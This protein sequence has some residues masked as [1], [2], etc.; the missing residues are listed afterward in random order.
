[1]ANRGKLVWRNCII[2]VQKNKLSERGR[3]RE[4]CISTKREKK[5][6]Y[7]FGEGI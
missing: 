2:F 6:V 1:M 3:E 7:F 5:E 4:K